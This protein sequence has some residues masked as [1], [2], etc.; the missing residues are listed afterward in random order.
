MPGDVLLTKAGHILGYSAV[1]PSTFAHGNITSHLASIR[2]S[3]NIVPE[4][5]AAYLRSS[6]GLQQIY[7]WGHK[8]TRPELNTDEVR[9]IQVLLPPIEIQQRLVA[10]LDIARDARRA[11]LAQ[12]NALLAGLDGFVLEQLRIQMP[13]ES[14]THLA[15][16]IKRQDLNNRRLDSY[17]YTPF[18]KHVEHTVHDIHTEIVTLASQLATL[19]INGVDLRNYLESGSP[20]L[21]VQNVRPFEFVLDDVK[22]VVNDSTKAVK[23]YA[24][25]VLLT[26]KGTFGVAAMVT[27][28][29]EN[30][31][32]CSEI[33]LLRLSKTAKCLP[34][35]L[36]AWLNSSVAKTLFEQRKAGGIMGHLTQDVVSDFL[37]PIPPMDTQR[38]II[39]EVTLRREA[40]R[41]QRA[42]A[43]TL[44]QA[45]QARFEAQLLGRS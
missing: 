27:P 11:K 19:P 32:I 9:A 44:W 21:R 30:C 13:S 22:Y 35:Y 37:V 39:T 2:P 40:A 29:I 42:E 23:L 31:L 36:V 10:F 41:R 15:Y 5:L 25:D 1:F 7:R 17:F 18:F 14:K 20:Y 3:D 26:R 8:A 24:G 6:L 16:A 12:A 33:I 34:E 28:E 43:E 45:A 38:R 4:Y